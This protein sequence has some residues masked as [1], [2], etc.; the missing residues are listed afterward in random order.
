MILVQ[1][2]AQ[3]LAC[4]DE[5]TPAQAAIYDDVR[6]AYEAFI[7]TNAPAGTARVSERTYQRVAEG[8]KEWLERGTVDGPA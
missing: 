2:H 1:V 8:A 3:V 5:L 4:G 7:N 6:R